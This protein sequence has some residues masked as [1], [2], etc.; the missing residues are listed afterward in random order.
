MTIKEYRVC[1]FEISGCTSVEI[2]RGLG[3]G[4]PVTLDILGL[5]IPSSYTAGNRRLNVVRDCPRVGFLKLLQCP[6]IDRNGPLGSQAIEK[7]SH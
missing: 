4:A 5:E 7:S 3:K 6:D 1:K 2:T